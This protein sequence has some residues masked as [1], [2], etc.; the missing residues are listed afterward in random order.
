MLGTSSWSFLI[1]SL[2]FV[3]LT[4][5][6]IGQKLESS[7]N[8]SLR[9]VIV[10][11]KKL[12]EAHPLG[13]AARVRGAAA[14]GADLAGH[15]VLELEELL[16]GRHLRRGLGQAELLR[17]AALH[18][19]SVVFIIEWKERNGSNRTVAGEEMHLPGQVPTSP[20]GV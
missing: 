13:D 17:Q 5:I 4:W 15:G 14:L 10:A 20:G 8:C 2:I 11:R 9:F 6:A 12:V 19:R 1:R 3:L 18:H 7:A 16:D